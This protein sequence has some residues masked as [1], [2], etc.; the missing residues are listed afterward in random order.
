MRFIGD[1]HA[2]FDRYLELTETAE[3]SIQVGDFG[4]GFRDLPLIST[5]HRFIRGN[6][7][8]PAICRNSPNWIPDCT[9]EDRIMF[10]GGGESIDRVNRTEGLDW[11][12]DEQLSTDQFFQAMDTWENSHADIMVTHECPHDI[13]PLLF[14]KRG[15]KVRNPSK[16]SQALSSILWIR[17][18]KI[19]IFGHWHI[20][21]DEVIDGTRF[22]CLGE[23]Q[24]ID[25]DI[26]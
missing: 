11:W 21:V 10:V 22:I 1:V 20:G 12:A 6:H 4:A 23:L 13:S 3:S 9:V 8:N 16:T 7:D 26:G 18:P 15:M 2:K 19:W 14:D 5:D 24:A 25:L 17:R